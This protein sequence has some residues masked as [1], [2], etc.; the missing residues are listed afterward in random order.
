MRLAFIMNNRF[1]PWGG[2]EELW[3]QSA[4]RLREA[5]HDVKVCMPAWRPLPPLLKRLSA[6]G[7]AIHQEDLPRGAYVRHRLRRMFNLAP[8]PEWEERAVV[9]WLRPF[10]PHLVI[11]S[12]MTNFDGAAWA[13]AC[14]RH[15]LRYAL[16]AQAANDTI[17]PGN[18]EFSAIRRAYLKAQAI[19]FVSSQNRHFT[20][21]ALGLALPQ[22]RVVRNP[23]LVPY[24]DPPAWPEPRTGLRLA[25]VA[26]L[27]YGKGQD[28]LFHVLALPVWRERALSVSLFGDGQNRLSQQAMV[29][30]LGLRDR[31]SFAGH[32]LDVR[33]I[34]RT[35]HALVLP[36]RA[37]G[38][39][40]AL[41]ESALCHRP[42]IVTPAGGIPEVIR[43]GETAFLAE[44][45]TAESFCATLERAWNRRA[46]WE[47]MGLA[48]GRHIRTLIPADPVG[49]FCQE[50]LAQ[51]RCS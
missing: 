49:S 43:K 22:A 51:I 20:S 37:E 12:Q 9:R 21:C 45:P 28:I 35:H 14:Q 23:F 32:V 44:A 40:L 10:K 11:V 33:E 48:A 50:V 29:D 19:Y 5:G 13:S 16:I 26:R 2:S 3:G 39:P 25:M 6:A 47:P 30:F 15:Q 27:D 42:A 17:T 24:D 31:V 34:W 41:V 7:A 8:S 36:S 1:V 46:E 38:L 18:Q 4:L